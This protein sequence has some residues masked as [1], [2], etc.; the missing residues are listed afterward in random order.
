MKGCL[1]EVMAEFLP[2]SRERLHSRSSV[3]AENKCDGAQKSNLPFCRTGRVV[4][5][6]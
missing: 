3:E 2:V 5:M 6:W 4:L 1:M